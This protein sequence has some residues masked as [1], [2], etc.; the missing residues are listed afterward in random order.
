MRGVNTHAAFVAVLAT[1][2]LATTAALGQGIVNPFGQ[3]QIIIRTQ[4]SYYVWVDQTG[5]HVRWS[6]PSMQAFSGFITSNGQISGICAAAGGTPSWLSLTGAQ[7]AV[8]STSTRTGI[9]GFD[10]RT[11]GSAVTFNLQVNAGQLPPWGQLPAWLV[12]IGRGLANAL[13][14]PSFTLSAQPSWAQQSCREPH[15]SDVDRPVTD[16]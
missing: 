3:P 9:D 11:T 14:A 13:G 7:R 2:L 16:R 12:Y 6:T 10:F 5:W 15:L 8:F 4:P 1:T